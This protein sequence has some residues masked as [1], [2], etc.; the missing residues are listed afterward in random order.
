MELPFEAQA[1][2]ELWQAVEW[3]ESEREGYGELFLDEVEAKVA[4]AARFPHSGPRVFLPNVEPGH[5][6][7]R[8]P[9]GRFQYQVITAIVA[10]ERAVIAVAHTSRRPGYWQDRLR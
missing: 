10:G 8:F 9:L 5:D 7:R 3:Y 2:E 6:I 4:R 1:A